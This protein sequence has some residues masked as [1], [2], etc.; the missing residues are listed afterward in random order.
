M[1]MILLPDLFDLI[2]DRKSNPPTGSYTARLLAEGVAEIA[3]KVGE[4]ATEVVVA[5]LAE[6]D[7]RLVAETADLLYH[8]L[9]L[10]AWRDLTLEDVE[11]E[12][13]RRWQP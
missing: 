12:L 9:V 8:L 1:E 7:D 5:A 13:R 10:L 3:A 11:A 6:S 4:E 2:E